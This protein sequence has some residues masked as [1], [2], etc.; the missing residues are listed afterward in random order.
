MAHATKAA[1]IL[2]QNYREKRIRKKTPNLSQKNL[3]ANYSQFANDSTKKTAL[4]VA[5][6]RPRLAARIVA[7]LVVA[8]SRLRVASSSL[9][10][11]NLS[12]LSSSS[13]AVLAGTG[14]KS[15]RD[16]RCPLV[17]SAEKRGK[18]TAGR[19]KLGTWGGNRGALHDIDGYPTRLSKIVIHSGHAVDSLSFEYD[20]DGKTFKAGP[21]GGSGGDP[22]KIEFKPGEYLTEIKGTVGTF[23]D[24]DNLVRSLTF[25]TNVN[26]SYGPFGV[27]QGTRFSVPV[28]HGRIVALYGRSGTYLDAIGVYLMR[29]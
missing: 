28:A 13:S 26:K 17:P 18:E 7:A 14:S 8:D 21:W 29:N 27:E 19:V 3:F 5:D 11:P 20:R 10:S 25:V 1:H 6:S 9:S 12:G 15:R 4:T 24:I 16:G 2:L 23:A 22:T